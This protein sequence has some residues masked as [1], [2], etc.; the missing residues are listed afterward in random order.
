MKLAL[1]SLS[2]F[3]I[4]ILAACGNLREKFGRKEGGY[5]KVSLSNQ[6]RTAATLNGGL[7]VYFVEVAPK[8]GGLGFGFQTE[9]A[10]LNRALAIPNG[11]YKVYAIGYDGAANLEGDG[12]CGYGN[13]GAVVTLSGGA[14]NVNLDI[15]RDTCNFGAGT[16]FAHGLGSDYTNFDRLTLN[17]CINNPFPTCTTDTAPTYYARIGLAG[18]VAPEQAGFVVNPAETIYSTCYGPTSAGLLPTN[19]RPPIGSSTFSP[20]VTIQ[21]YTDAG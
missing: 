6:S 15:S 11:A 20:P 7:M 13:G 18:G 2:V 4:L 12:F 17:F 14:T 5:T 9:T 19:A 16:V 8:D 3:G 21:L 10:A 1:L